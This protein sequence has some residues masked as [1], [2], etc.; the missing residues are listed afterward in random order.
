MVMVFERRLRCKAGDRIMT[1]VCVP[2]VFGECF[3]QGSRME[4]SN[5]AMPTPT[6][7]HVHEGGG[8]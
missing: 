5:L 1:E 7:R 8:G 6:L 2:L 4:S 3:E